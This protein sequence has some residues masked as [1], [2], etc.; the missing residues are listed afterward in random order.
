VPPNIFKPTDI[1]CIPHKIILNLIIT[2]FKKDLQLHSYGDIN[3]LLRMADMDFFEFFS[4]HLRIGRRTVRLNL[5]EY[6]NAVGAL[7]YTEAARKLNA[8]RDAVATA[9][10]EIKKS[11]TVLGDRARLLLIAAVACGVFAA[12]VFLIPGVAAAGWAFW[13]G[14]AAAA[15]GLS[16]LGSLGAAA[17]NTAE[18]W[19]QEDTAA[20]IAKDAAEREVDAKTAEQIGN[21]ND[22]FYG[23]EAA[24]NFIATTQSEDHIVIGGVNQ[25]PRVNGYNN[26]LFTAAATQAAFDHANKAMVLQK[27]PQ[28]GMGTFVARILATNTLTADANLKP[29][30]T[31]KYNKAIANLPDNDLAKTGMMLENTDLSRAKIKLLGN[32]FEIPLPATGHDIALMRTVFKSPNADKDQLYNRAFSAS[33]NNYLNAHFDTPDKIVGSSELAAL[34]TNGM[35]NFPE[36]QDIVKSFVQAKLDPAHPYNEGKTFAELTDA[37]QGAQAEAARLAQTEAEATTKRQA[38][39]ALERK[40]EELA[41]KFV[42]IRIAQ[43]ASGKSWQNYIL[44]TA[45][46]N[47]R[48]ILAAVIKHRQNLSADSEALERFNN[49][50]A[51]CMQTRQPANVANEAALFANL[52]DMAA[53]SKRR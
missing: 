48:D 5:R 15:G 44:D 32:T 12:G 8:A 52:L 41:E 51:A 9:K 47:Q 26:G 24:K 42:N 11:Q 36:M 22:R 53:M 37:H 29:H 25:L 20:V 28:E 34:Y 1:D 13:G 40:N 10:E 27:K 18:K 38:L 4:K 14:A 50:A 31:L 16:A 39:E 3:H 33:L 2:L 7:R 43:E 19:N 17:I 30:S 45:N 6:N 46:D 35:A 21:L 23:T 49:V